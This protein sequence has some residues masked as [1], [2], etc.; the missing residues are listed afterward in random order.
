MSGPAVQEYSIILPTVWELGTETELVADL[1]EHT[2]REVPV[3]SLQEKVVTIVATEVVV[4]GVPGALQCWIEVSPV[5]STTSAAYWAAIGG[6]GGAMPPLAPVVEAAV[7]V[8]GRVHTI[9]IPWTQHSAFA[10]LVIQ[11]PVAAT[12]AT[13]F[14]AVQALLSGKGP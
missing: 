2:S 13:A 10:R 14:W 7:G 4:V 3:D 12:P 8:N 5:P 6:G 1:L 11:T 9:V